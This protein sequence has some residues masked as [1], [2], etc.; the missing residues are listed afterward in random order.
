VF[1]YVYFKRLEGAEAELDRTVE[2]VGQLAH[3]FKV[4]LIG[5]DYGG[6]LDKND[7][8]MRIHGAA[9]IL[10]YQ[11]TGSGRVLHYDPKLGRY[12]ANR[13]EV[14]MAYI[15]AINRLDVF[16]F[17]RW[18]TWKTPFAENY[19]AVHQEYSESQRAMVITK[20]PGVADDALHAGALCFLAATAHRPRVDIFRPDRPRGD[21]DDG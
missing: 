12:M 17:P 4:H 19:T 14:L 13:N 6:G 20:S 9:K 18:E 15:N 7:R 8:L 1:T 10:R 21:Q 3:H 16:K 5:T 2:I 11:Y